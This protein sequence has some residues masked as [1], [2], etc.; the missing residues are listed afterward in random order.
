MSDE[1]K[2]EEPDFEKDSLLDFS[3]GPTELSSAKPSKLGKKPDEDSDS[4]ESSLKMETIQMATIKERIKE[5][6]KII[7]EAKKSKTR[8]TQKAEPSETKEE[9]VDFTPIEKTKPVVEPEKPQ[10][11][12]PEGPP[13]MPWEIDVYGRPLKDKT[14]EKEKTSYEI[15]L[16]EKREKEGVKI[17]CPNCGA[18]NIDLPFVTGEKCS[19][20]GFNLDAD[21]D[22]TKK[23]QA[24]D[25]RA[26]MG[27]KTRVS[28]F[29]TTSLKMSLD[30]PDEI[31]NN[32]DI[33]FNGEC[34]SN[35]YITYLLVAIAAT[36]GA[37]VFMVRLAIA[38]VTHSFDFYMM[39]FLIIVA[40]FAYYGLKQTLLVTRIQ[41]DQEGATFYGSSAPI[42]IKYK[43]I[44]AITNKR[45]LNGRARF[46]NPNTSPGLMF[47]LFGRLYFTYRRYDHDYYW[48][49]IPDTSAISPY[50]NNHITLKTH[51]VQ[52][53]WVFCGHGNHEFIR[54]LALLIYL[55]K[56]RNNNC[57]VDIPAIRA[58]DKVVVDYPDLY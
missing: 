48:E 46:L 57:H 13:L 36:I 16:D 4:D 47:L 25:Q 50:Y 45:L 33:R 27:S 43:N 40:I 38:H 37:L 26:G 6:D 18:D 7:E 11:E 17:K 54:A 23:M 30:L 56:T 12:E 39:S 5:L 1:D 51:N 28:E 2:I 19:E 24:R 3:K 58:A 22:L 21:E 44:A 31:V 8:E 42:R 53:K 9:T 20:C 14:R 15:W 55:G 29:S 34:R 41:L 52:I 49:N 32:P 35:S 10:V